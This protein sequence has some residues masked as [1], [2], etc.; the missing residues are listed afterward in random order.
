MTIYRYIYTNIYIYIVHRHEE[1]GI[2]VLHLI[3]CG[4]HGTGCLYRTLELQP[5]PG[6]R[7][8][9]SFLAKVSAKSGQTM[10]EKYGA[11]PV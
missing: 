3:H 7:A 11:V 8:T 2:E 4:A 10:V 9:S 5:G 6:G 1:W